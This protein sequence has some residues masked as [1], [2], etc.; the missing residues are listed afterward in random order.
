MPPP[1]RLFVNHSRTR[2]F[3]YHHRSFSFRNTRRHDLGDRVHLSQEGH[4]KHPPQPVEKGIMQTLS[5][6]V[7]PLEFGLDFT[8]PGHVECPICVA[9]LQRVVYET[10]KHLP[11]LEEL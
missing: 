1:T 6:N 7:E 9:A 2:V 11:P 8:T 5:R 10:T 4:S 3:Y